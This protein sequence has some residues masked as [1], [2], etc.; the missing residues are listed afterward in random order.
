M[1]EKMSFAKGGVIAIV[2]SNKQ[3]LGKKGVKKRNT[4]ATVNQEL[5]WGNDNEQFKGN[6]SRGSN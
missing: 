1:I 5:I 3:N 6:G 2:Q 4:F